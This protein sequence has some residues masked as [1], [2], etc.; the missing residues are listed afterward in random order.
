MIATPVAFAAG[1]RLVTVGAV[2]SAPEPVVKVQLKGAAMA[3]LAVSR[4][5]VLT[6]AA[7]RV[8][9]GRAAV[10]VKVATFP[11]DA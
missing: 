2:T 8:L 11:V 4:A 7:Q 9:A 3:L 10:G 6:V 1:L 5:P